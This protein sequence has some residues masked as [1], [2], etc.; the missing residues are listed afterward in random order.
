MNRRKEP[1]R[2]EPRRKDG[3]RRSSHIRQSAWATVREPIEEQ[4][5][6]ATQETFDENINL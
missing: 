3:R 4:Q 5:P 2:H 1:R 6:A